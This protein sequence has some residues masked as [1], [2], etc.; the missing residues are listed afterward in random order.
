MENTKPKKS[1]LET[2]GNTSIIVGLFAFAVPALAVFG[3]D[4]PLQV[5][6]KTFGPF[7][8][9]GV[10]IAVFIASSVL[11]MLLGTVNRI[12]PLLSGFGTG[13]VLF[14]GAFDLPYLASIR[15]ALFRF[16][17]F[18]QP[19]P[20]LFAGALAIIT[21]L[22][23]ARS[24]KLKVLPA[25][26]G[27]SIPALLLLFILTAWSPFTASSASLGMDASTFEKALQS[28]SATMGKSYVNPE[29]EKAVRQVVEE[30]DKTLQKKE[31]ALK[32]LSERLARSEEDKKA[33]ERSVKDSALLSKELEAAKQVIK[34]LQ[35]RIEKDNAPVKGGRY[36]LAVQPTNP[37][38][39]DFAV[40]IA[41]A[42][43]GPWDDPQGSKIPNAAG[44]K[45][46]VLIHGAL[47]RNWKYVSDP[48]V[49]WTDYT[50]PASRTIALSLAG[51]CDDYASV[52]ASC[53]IAV[54]GRSRIIHG[55]RGQQG[56]AWAEVWIGRGAVAD[57]VL[58]AVAPYS[59]KNSMNLAVSRDTATDDRWLVLDWELGR[60]SF[61]GSTMTVA[62]TS[63]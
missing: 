30:K 5:I 55:F 57:R 44:A 10:L 1:V 51:D 19:G 35:G 8:E 41:A 52:M 28:I 42:A 20:A 14:A 39:R 6:K 45:Q 11:T 54:G 16:P 22:F 15:S 2:I 18:S 48:A 23:M 59:G 13:I 50:S 53:I 37:L 34:D 47:S 21:G 24:E 29:V 31:K 63:N 58:Q 60:Y 25:L 46:L 36:D 61:P 26:L 17:P 62:W 32:E 9:P 12:L 43:P 49:S 27:P 3:I 33:L 4:Q 40:K 56:H 38:V 7:G